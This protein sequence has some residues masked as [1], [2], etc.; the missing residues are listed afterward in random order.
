[1]RGGIFADIRGALAVARNRSR[2]E[3]DVPRTR[4]KQLIL[5]VE[6]TVEALRPFA[7]NAHRF[8]GREGDEE[9]YVWGTD[10]PAGSAPGIRGGDFRR[11]AEAYRAVRDP[12]GLF[13]SQDP[14]AVRPGDPIDLGRIERVLD[15]LDQ[16]LEALVPFANMLDGLYAPGEDTSRDYMIWSWRDDSGNEAGISTAEIKRARLSLEQGAEIE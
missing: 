16:S 15:G 5:K 10:D 11:A 8:H 3:L 7:E 9:V 12:M 14:R 13:F 6:Q 1:M 4:L 2:A